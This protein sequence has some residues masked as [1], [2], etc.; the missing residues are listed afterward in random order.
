MSDFICHDNC[1]LYQI[2]IMDL[3]NMIITL[4]ILLHVTN[5]LLYYTTTHTS[6]HL[7][8]VWCLCVAIASSVRSL[9]LKPANASLFLH[10]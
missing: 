4:S 5:I 1:Q 8:H 2:T 7:F 10:P 9:S 6:M 3:Y